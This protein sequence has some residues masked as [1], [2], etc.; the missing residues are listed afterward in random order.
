MDGRLVELCA[1]RIII[2][3]LM[4]MSWGLK[5]LGKCLKVTV[6]QAVDV[7]SLLCQTVLIDH[8][9]LWYRQVKIHAEVST[10][11]CQMVSGKVLHNAAL[12]SVWEIIKRPLADWY[13]TRD[14]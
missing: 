7:E 8:K 3:T 5:A 1:A 14:S 9:F 10:S 2:S 4:S 6:V 12:A 13:S 11:Q